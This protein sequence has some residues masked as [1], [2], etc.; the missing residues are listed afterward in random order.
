MGLIHVLFFF[1]HST[2]CVI[3]CRFFLSIITEFWT[4]LIYMYVA[5][6]LVWLSRHEVARPDAFVICMKIAWY[7]PGNELFYLSFIFSVPLPCK[8]TDWSE[9]TNCT[10]DC[11]GCTPQR[12]RYRN[13]TR[14]ATDGTKCRTNQKDPCETRESN[15]H[16]IVITYCFSWYKVS[17]II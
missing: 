11:A 17:K 2:L 6:L 3:T 7:H 15:N 10:A 5:I 4:I 13:I 1:R 9:W 14:P 12:T 16:W 8:T